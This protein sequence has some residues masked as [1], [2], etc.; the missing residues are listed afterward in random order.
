MSVVHD[1]ETV[2]SAIF[3]FSNWYLDFANH[4]L[5]S[6]CFYNILASNSLSAMIYHHRSLGLVSCCPLWLY[7]PLG[8]WTMHKLLNVI[9]GFLSSREHH[10][11]LAS[12]IVHVACKWSYCW[13][14]QRC[15]SLLPTEFHPNSVKALSPV[16]SQ[17]DN[18]LTY[19]SS[20]SL[21][22]PQDSWLLQ[23]HCANTV[24][25]PHLLTMS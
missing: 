15:R 12:F 22:P 10:F 19:Q 14:S 23:Q 6:F 13:A 3:H 20:L 16:A 17:E 1:L 7:C 9:N 4:L 25:C 5:M 21:S 2:R 11:I 8:K 18:V 24:Q